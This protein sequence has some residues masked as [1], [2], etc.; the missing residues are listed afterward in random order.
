MYELVRSLV[1]APSAATGPVR[2]VPESA[3]ATQARTHPATAWA[4]AVTAALV[5]LFLLPSGPAMTL[6]PGTDLSPAERVAFMAAATLASIAIWRARSLRPGLHPPSTPA[7]LLGAR[8]CFARRAVHDVMPAVQSSPRATG[9]GSFGTGC[10]SAWGGP[11]AVEA[12]ARN[13]AAW[14]ALPAPSDR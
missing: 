14:P 6:V 12:K 4:I 11:F 5:C 2:A 7:A 8:V 3:S 13:V 9:P 1:S 10:G